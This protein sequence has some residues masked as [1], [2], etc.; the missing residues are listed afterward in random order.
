[1]TLLLV[2]SSPSFAYLGPGGGL[3]AIGALLS[4]IVAVFYTFTGLIWF[5]LKQFFKKLKNKDGDK[6]KTEKKNPAKAP[7][8]T[9]PSQMLNKSQPD[10]NNINQIK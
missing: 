2:A 8:Q 6:D 3:T 1:M 9:Q 4:L 5:P 7:M 10:A